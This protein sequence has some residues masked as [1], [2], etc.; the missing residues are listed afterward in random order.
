MKMVSVVLF[1][2]KINVIKQFIKRGLRQGGETTANLSV[3]WGMEAS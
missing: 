2:H 1:F 3:G